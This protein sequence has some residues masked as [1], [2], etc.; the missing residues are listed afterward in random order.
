M[1]LADSRRELRRTRRLE[2]LRPRDGQFSSISTEPR[3]ENPE[4]G[5]DLERRAES[6]IF[7]STVIG[8]GASKNA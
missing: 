4:N 3:L 8:S 6:E 1:H 5:R 7:I 2:E